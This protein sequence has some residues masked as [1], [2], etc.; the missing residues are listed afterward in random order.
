MSRTPVTTDR[1]AIELALI[2]VTGHR[3]AGIDCC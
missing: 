2:G 1:A 3:V